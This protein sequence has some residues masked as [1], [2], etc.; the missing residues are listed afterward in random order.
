MVAGIRARKDR[1][2]A[3]K[4][5]SKTAGQGMA[6]LFDLAPLVHDAPEERAVRRPTKPPE[7]A[8]P[9]YPIPYWIRGVFRFGNG[10][11]ST[12]T[13]AGQAMSNRRNANIVTFVDYLREE[14]WLFP[15]GRAVMVELLG[16]GGEDGGAIF[17]LQETH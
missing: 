4:R 16:I 8:L 2:M 15:E 7:A 14:G 5:R 17:L 1:T 10:H 9:P 11:E 13:V 12:R 3:G 6:P